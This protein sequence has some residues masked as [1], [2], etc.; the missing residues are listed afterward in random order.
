MNAD[1]YISIKQYCKHTHISN[2]FIEALHQYGLIKV[3]AVEEEVCIVEEEITEIERF[4]RLYHSLGIN[5]EG[6]DVINNILK[7]VRH[8]EQERS[9]LQARLRAF[10]DLV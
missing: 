8:L 1:N 9:I 3:I 10:E 6:L 7:R 4:D 5:L 2:T